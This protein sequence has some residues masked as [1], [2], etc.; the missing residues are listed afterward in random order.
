MRK[1]LYIIIVITG[2]FAGCSHSPAKP[3][4]IK[5]VA[6]L[7]LADFDTFF[8]EFKSDSVYQVLHVKFPFRTI[9]SG[10]EGSDT[11]KYI[12]KDKWRNISFKNEK[13][14]IYKRNQ[15]SKTEVVIKYMVEDTGIYNE[16]DFLYNNGKWQLVG[17]RDGSD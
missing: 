9:A 11:V 4:L 8:K 16:F 3:T 10:E 5:K 17:F 13:G 1:L 14:D 15:L 6:N 12:P 7:E 2:A